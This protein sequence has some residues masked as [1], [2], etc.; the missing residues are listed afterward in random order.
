MTNTTN[1]TI[2]YQAA[3]GA[4]ELRGDVDA[5]TVWAT[6]AQ[7]AELFGVNTQA[8]TKH[9]KKIYQEKELDHAETCSK[10]EQVRTEGMR[11]VHRSVMQYNLDVMISVGYRINSR[12]GTHFRQWATKVLGAH[13]VTG[14]TIQPHRVQKNY[15]KFM[16]AIAQVQKLLPDTAE[17]DT[18]H[19]IE[20]VKMFATTWLSLDAFDR[21]ELPKVG[22]RKEQVSVTTGELVEAISALK[23]DLVGRHAATPLFGQERQKGSLDG[24]VGSVFQSAF[25]AD[26]Y[27]T[28]EEKAAHLLYFFVKDH[29]FVDGNKRIGA[30]AFIWFLNKAGLL[31]KISVDP[32]MLTALTLLI[33][34]SNPTDKPRMIGLILLFLSQ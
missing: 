21:S 5:Q 22:A 3:T 25:G 23:N 32:K 27:P 16:Q 7:M 12:T 33:A 10:T 14:F 6:Q 17:H 15:E 34:Q 11:R 2:V 29:P 18:K 8:I 30:Y 26:A 19:I 31:Q 20:L 9:I 13:I 24:I 28:I 1:P 4:I